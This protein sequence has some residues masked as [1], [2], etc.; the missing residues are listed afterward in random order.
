[1]ANFIVLFSKARYLNIFLF[2][3]A[4][5][6]NGTSVFLWTGSRSNPATNRLAKRAAS[7]RFHVLLIHDMLFSFF[8]F[9]AF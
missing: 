7:V 8:P 6:D 5:L 4:I 1:M 9:L 2:P 3:A